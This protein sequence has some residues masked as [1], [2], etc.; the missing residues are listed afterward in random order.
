M[1]SYILISYGLTGE[2]HL[3][4]VVHCLSLALQLL[5]SLL[6]SFKEIFA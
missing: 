5:H 1:L 4:I 3:I 6:L 2:H